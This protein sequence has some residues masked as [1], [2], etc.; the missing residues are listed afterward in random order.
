M[1]LI[2]YKDGNKAISCAGCRKTIEMNDSRWLL[3]GSDHLYYCRACASV[4]KEDMDETLREAIDEMSDIFLGLFDRIYV[5]RSD[6]K[7]IDM[8]AL[9]SM[10]DTI[11]I[12]RRK[13]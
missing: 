3:R 12:Q 6:V 2:E 11:F 4:I 10:S 8:Q 5:K 9:A 1:S 13:R 7:A